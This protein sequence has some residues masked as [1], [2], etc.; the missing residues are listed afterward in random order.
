VAA[1][2]AVFLRPAALDSVL[3]AVVVKIPAD[4]LGLAGS[5]SAEL[6]GLGG[7]AETVESVRL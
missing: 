3:V 5:D 4:S 1:M 6:V 7:R 2:R